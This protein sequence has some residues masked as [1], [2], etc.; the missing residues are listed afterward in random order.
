[1]TEP[2]RGFRIF[3]DD[4]QVSGRIVDLTLDDLN[5]G[6][7]LIKAAYSS[8]NF[9]DALAATGQGHIVRRFP[10]VGGIDVA[11]TV[12]SSTDLRFRK[13]DPVIVTGYGLGVSADGGYA[14]YVRVPAEWVIPLP[15]G[16][17][18]FDGAQRPDPGCRSGHRH[19]RHRR[20]RQHGRRLPRRSRL[21]GDRSHRQR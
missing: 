13:K 2:F 5:P 19:R 15:P 1:V 18:A 10:L 6:A 12:E 11:G 14:G 9:K 16:L 3:Q 8:V 7:V 20:R 4:G 21:S 17:S